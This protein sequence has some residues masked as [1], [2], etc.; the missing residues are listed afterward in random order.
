MQFADTVI[1]KQYGGQEDVSE[2]GEYIGS[3]VIE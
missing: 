2:L 3:W 1:V